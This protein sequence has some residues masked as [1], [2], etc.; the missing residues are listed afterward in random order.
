MVD[1]NAVVA[2]AC[3]GSRSES[4]ATLRSLTPP[5]QP[6]IAN[7]LSNEKDAIK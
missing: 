4:E 2:L 1:V 3:E 7:Q 5:Q 6:L